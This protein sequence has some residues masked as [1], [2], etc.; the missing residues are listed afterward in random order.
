MDNQ[1]K[2]MD[3]HSLNHKYKNLVLVLLCFLAMEQLFG[4]KDENDDVGNLY[5]VWWQ[6][7]KY[8]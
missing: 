7:C 6:C 3:Q 5:I 4:N 2:T 1:R 8:F